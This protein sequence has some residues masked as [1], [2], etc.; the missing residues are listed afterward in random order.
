MAMESVSPVHFA[1]NHIM[2]CLEFTCHEF[3]CNVSDIQSCIVS[4]RIPR[5]SSLLPSCEIDPSLGLLGINNVIP[6]M[7]CSFS[8]DLRS[9]C[10]V[11][12]RRFARRFVSSEGSVVVFVVDEVGRLWVAER[13]AS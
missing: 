2:R 6:A 7:R 11:R 1:Q 12:A 5:N 10:C 8:R 4:S 3:M 9:D 13:V